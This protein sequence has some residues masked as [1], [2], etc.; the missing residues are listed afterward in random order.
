MLWNVSKSLQVDPL[1]V[2]DDALQVETGR[3]S[4]LQE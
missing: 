3:G 2:R 4:P 1:P